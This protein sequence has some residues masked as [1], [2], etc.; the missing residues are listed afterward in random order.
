MAQDGRQGAPAGAASE[1]FR[2][3][4]ILQIDLVPA[5]GIVRQQLGEL[6][7]TRDPDAA[8]TDV[9]IGDPRSRAGDSARSELIILVTYSEC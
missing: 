4:N 6:P 8:R 9:G 3:D 5:L 2:G 7:W 1:L